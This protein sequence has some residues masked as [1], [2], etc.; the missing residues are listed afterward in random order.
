M[1]ASIILSLCQMCPI[2]PTDL[3]ENGK[4]LPESE[5][6]LTWT[7]WMAHHGGK[8]FTGPEEPF[9]RLCY[10]YGRS[11]PSLQAQASPGLFVGWFLEPGCNY[12]GVLLIADYQKM[13]QVET[14]T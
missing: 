7:C 9:G 11:N 3:D 5:Y 14:K 12:R 13:L 1:Y 2:L 6:K 4:T 8:K 10:Y